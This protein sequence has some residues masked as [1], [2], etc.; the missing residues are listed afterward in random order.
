MK[1]AEYGTLILHCEWCKFGE[2]TCYIFGDIEFSLGLF[3]IGA[4]DTVKCVV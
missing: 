4:P 2:T 3:L 1:S